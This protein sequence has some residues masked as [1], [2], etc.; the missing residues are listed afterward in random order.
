MQGFFLSKKQTKSLGPNCTQSDGLCMEIKNPMHSP[1]DSAQLGPNEFF[2][3][4]D[5]NLHY[6]NFDRKCSRIG[7]FR[8]KEMRVLELINKLDAEPCT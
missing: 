2:C 8:R 6:N 3:F 7:T 1:Y 4:L 5:K